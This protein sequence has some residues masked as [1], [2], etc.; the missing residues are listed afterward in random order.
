MSNVVGVNETINWCALNSLYDNILYPEIESKDVKRMKSVISEKSGMLNSTQLANY[1]GKSP[2][3][4]TRWLKDSDIPHI[5]KNGRA[6]FYR[7]KVDEW[8]NLK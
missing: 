4:I 2:A 7:D 3:T 8:L 6:V 5:R 1:L